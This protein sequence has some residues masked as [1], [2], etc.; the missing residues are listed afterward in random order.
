M[1]TA[2]LYYR[3]AEKEVVEL[4]KHLKESQFWPYEKIRAYQFKKL[5]VLLGQ[6][7]SDVPYYR[8]MFQELK[9]SPKDIRS[10]DDFKLLPVLTKDIIRKNSDNLINNKLIDHLLPNS[11]GGSTGEPL[12]FYQDGNYH[13]WAEA[14]RIRGWYHMPGCEFGAG[15]AVLWGEMK[16]VREDYTP[17][18]RIRDFLQWGQISM[19]AFNLS[20]ERKIHFIKWCRALRPPLVRGYVTALKDLALFLEEEHIKFP[21]IKGVLLCAETVDEPTQSYIEKIFKAPSFNMYGGRELSLIG[22]ECAEKNGL[23]EVSENNYVEFENITIS[24]YEKAGN[25]II[26]NLN[27]FGMPFIR[28]RIGDIGVPGG[29]RNCGCGRNL[30]LIKKVIGRS[31]EVF[32]FYEGTR[33]AGE[34]FIHLMKE[35]PVKEYQFVQVNDSNVILRLKKS[36]NYNDDTKNQIT[37]LFKRY[38]PENVTL[39]IVLVD[40][41][42]KTTTGKF[43][44]V[45]REF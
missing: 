15:C 13:L 28:Y 24:N 35:F 3:F 2:N 1:I 26:T 40:G 8:N 23:H 12:H 7:Y 6:A 25:L 14:A 30:P 45:Y 33:I 32:I 39:T 37:S 20:R 16:E 21:K 34:M 17:Y 9:A 10:F 43:R 18:E 42:E 19:N 36:E 31:T 4:L 29:N 38:L 11:T 27:N 41:F 5:K 44:F 22:M